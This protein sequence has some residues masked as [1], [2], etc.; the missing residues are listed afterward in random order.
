MLLVYS[1][2]GLADENKLLTLPI[3]YTKGFILFSNHT[4]GQ[5]V[6]VEMAVRPNNLQSATIVTSTPTLDGRAYWCSLGV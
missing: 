6:T 2:G 4:T 5:G 3:S 1:Q